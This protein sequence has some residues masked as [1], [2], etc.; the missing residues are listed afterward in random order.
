MNDE[1]KDDVT[2][3]GEKSDKSASLPMVMIGEETA[4]SLLEFLNAHCYGR[5][6]AEEK[7]ELAKAIESLEGWPKLS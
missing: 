4:R 5:M 7:A 6:M 2:I 3:G 1:I